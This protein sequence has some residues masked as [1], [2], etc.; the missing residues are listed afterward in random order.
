MN[1][2]QIEVALERKIADDIFQQLWYKIEH[3]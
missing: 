3:Q 1:F 2:K